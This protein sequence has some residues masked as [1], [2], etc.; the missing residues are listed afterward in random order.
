MLFCVIL[1]YVS[2]HCTCNKGTMAQNSRGMFF[3][4]IELMTLGMIN[5]ALILYLI[6]MKCKQTQV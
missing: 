4:V 3:A 6:K 5:I 1:V 2:L